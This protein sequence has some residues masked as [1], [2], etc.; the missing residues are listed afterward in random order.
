MINNDT[1]HKYLKIEFSFLYDNQ[2]MKEEL[3][4]KKTLIRDIVLK[5]ITS[6]KSSELSN[7]NNLKN[8]KIELINKINLKLSKGQVK[9]IYFDDFLML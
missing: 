7:T 3:E 2:D 5:I 1:K 4:E 6:K 9:E 8:F